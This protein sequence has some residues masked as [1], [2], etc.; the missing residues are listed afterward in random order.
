MGSLT[1]R[2]LVLGTVFCLPTCISPAIAAVPEPE[3]YRLDDYHAPVPASVPGGSVI[4]SASALQN[5]LAQKNALLIDVLPAQRR[6]AGM[7][8]AT[9]W[10][11]EPHLDIPGSIWLPDSGRGA[12]SPAAAAWF[13]AELGTLTHNDRARPLVFYCQAQCWMSW[14]AAKRAAAEGYR[15]VFWY[16]EGVDG[17]KRAG[18]ALAPA[19]PASQAPEGPLK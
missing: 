4:P 18:F 11:P 16:P 7:K 10:L 19:K 3:G 2:R 12:L 14:N 1:R 8:P 6:P 5:L 13:R 9:P 15:R 17:W